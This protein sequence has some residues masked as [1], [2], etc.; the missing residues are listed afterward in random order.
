MSTVAVLKIRQLLLLRYDC[1]VFDYKALPV[2]TVHRWLVVH[3]ELTLIVGCVCS[4]SSHQSSLGRSFVDLLLPSCLADGR[5][6]RPLVIRII[7]AAR[8]GRPELTSSLD[9]AVT[10]RPDAGQLRSKVQ[11]PICHP[12]CRRIVG[13]GNVSSWVGLIRVLLVA[14][15]F[16]SF[17]PL[18]HFVTQDR[19]HLGPPVDNVWIVK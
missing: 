15:S 14:S 9:T 1:L 4:V 2:S 11:R 13:S 16:P 17:Q 19:T 8:P 6:A 12:T 18:K 7:A 10:Q 5:R 3:V